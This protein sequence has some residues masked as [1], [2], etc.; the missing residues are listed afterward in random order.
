MIS[1]CPA[2]SRAASSA[3][4]QSGA[5]VPVR[6]CVLGGV[7]VVG[8][9][10]REGAALVGRGVVRSVLAL[11]ASSR[12][13]VP[14][15]ELTDALWPRHEAQAARNRLHHTLHL[16]RRALNELA[17]AGDWI[18]V[19]RGRLRLDPRVWCD[20]WEVKD[21]ASGAFEVLSTPALAN[22]LEL[23]QGDWAPEVEAAGLGQAIR[24][25]L[26]EAHVRLRAEMARRLA[27]D[28][29][30]P[31]L[32]A[33]LQALVELSETDEWA[34]CQLMQLDLQAGR[35]HSVLRRFESLGKLLA[36]GL[37]LRPSR[38][39][40]EIAA[41]AARRIDESAPGSVE[42]I[43]AAPA[44]AVPASAGPLLGREPLLRALC[45]EIAVAPG[46]WNVTG[47][48]GVGKSALMREVMRRTAPMLDGG[49]VY[50]RQEQ[51][52]DGVV[53]AAVRAAG[54][55]G[56]TGAADE[57]LT[58]L[59]CEREVLLVLDDF[60]QASDASA[61]TALLERPLR[62]RVVLITSF[63]LDAQR[64]R[65]EAVQVPPLAVA[66][67]GAAPSEARL[68]PAVALFQLRCASWHD[69]DP[70]ETELRDV[71]ALVDELGG[72]PLAIELAAAQTDA[73]TPGEIL[74]QVRGGSGLA[75]TALSRAAPA[76]GP[77]RRTMRDALD[78][79]VGLI[80]PI[81]RLLYQAVSVF[82]APFGVEAV[83]A[84][85]VRAALPDPERL[86]NA[87]PRLA[88]CGLIEP[89]PG[90]GTYR[91]LLVPRAHACGMARASG[92][93]TSLECAHIDVLI[94]EL[95]SGAVG[96]ESPLYENWLVRVRDREDEALAQLEAARRVG[97]A[98]LVRLAGPLVQALAVRGQGLAVLHWCE[99]AVQASV[100]SAEPHAE[101]L[102]RTFCAIILLA[103]QRTDQALPYAR[104]GAELAR[105][106]KDTALAALSVATLA[107]AINVAGSVDESLAV[108]RERFGSH[109]KPDEPGFWTVFAAMGRI[110][111]SGIAPALDAPGP[112]VPPLRVLRARFAGSLLWRHLLVALA[113]LNPEP[114]ARLEV[115]DELV[116][117]GRQMDLTPSVVSG[118]FFRV[119]A[120]LSLGQHDAADLDLSEWYRLARDDGDSLGAG[121]S[122]LLKVELAWRLGDLDKAALWLG[123]ARRHIRPDEHAEQ[124]RVL[125]LHEAAVA[126]LRGDEAAATRA[127][128][129]AASGGAAELRLSSLESAIEVGAMLAGLSGHRELAQ[130]LADHLALLSP[131]QFHPPAV[132]RFRAQHLPA[133]RRLPPAGEVSQAASVLA[134]GVADQG[135]DAVA[136][137]AR[138]DIQSL[139]ERL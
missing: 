103:A 110:R 98:Q 100:R 36:L 4:A 101:L 104:A 10:G 6:I 113:T 11:A 5:V 26:H 20:A 96:H 68:S 30:T 126:T 60:D 74:A 14:R 70:D 17:G 99:L 33:A 114:A 133:A 40:S 86:V 45:G 55:R 128:V 52:W 79:F 48:T 139:L 107:Q 90:T 124:Y 23:C 95:E 115:A 66:P 119:Q 123:E 9:D 39:A 34:H 97:D 88:R 7:S 111:R 25:Q 106:E 64:F 121:R 3:Y 89:R 35:Y 131:P 117:T 31:A 105:T 57:L 93:W 53:A 84:L 24:R 81:D 32:R 2:A 116:N 56:Q 15:D 16:V 137:R 12:Q 82:A 94:E 109:P 21:A 87:L 69:R 91:M 75:P 85:C 118:L 13:G 130:S 120:R 92:L 134:A 80:D 62:A 37:G 138:A 50:V 54:L 29:D 78:V 61:L 18:V 83:R 129:A 136:A 127:F 47:M 46:V 1:T 59:L 112:G 19:D 71:V 42:S 49:V 27:A 65:V 73:R 38:Q 132:T 77:C 67:A 125:M 102:F 41:R 22:T 72:L 76:A 8:A 122:C 108:L 43:A 63:P 28:G 58:R 44:D 51:A 135:P